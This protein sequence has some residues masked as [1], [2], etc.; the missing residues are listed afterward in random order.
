MNKP[1]SLDERVKLLLLLKFRIVLAIKT[2]NYDK[3]NYD[4]IG[5]DP[6]PIHNLETLAD[7]SD[8][9]KM[10]NFFII[11]VNLSEYK[12]T[13]YFTMVLFEYQV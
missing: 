8:I 5:F 10:I 6:S 11:E 7:N 3:I 2:I 13:N 1:Y 9:K 12:Q 4:L